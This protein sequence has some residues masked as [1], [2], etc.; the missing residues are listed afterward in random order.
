MCFPAT[1]QPYMLLAGMGMP[2]L[3]KIQPVLGRVLA[4]ALMTRK[5][6]L[7]R[8]KSDSQ[9]KLDFYQAKE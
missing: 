4:D 6:Y 2:K 8:Y 3:V 1:F 7:W 5:K 9:C